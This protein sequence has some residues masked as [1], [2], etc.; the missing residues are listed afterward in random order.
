[1]PG[2]SLAA[3]RVPGS[4]S[5]KKIWCLELSVSIHREGFASPVVKFRPAG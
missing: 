1:M 2:V 5:R 4:N 3:K